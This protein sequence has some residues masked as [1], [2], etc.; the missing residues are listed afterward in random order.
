MNAITKALNDTNRSYMAAKF[1]VD[2]RTAS[3]F[4]NNPGGPISQRADF[5]KASEQ[6][7]HFSG[8]VYASIR[9]I[10]Q[11]IAGQ[12]IHVGK[13]GSSTKL[14]L[15]SADKPDPID[16]HPLLDLLADPNNLMVAWSLMFSTVASL[17]LTGRCLWWLPDQ[18][19][20]LPIPTSWIVGYEGETAFESFKIKPPGSAEAISLPSDEVCYFSY[21][22]PAD[23]WGSTS[24]L[25]AVGRAVDAD[26]A[27]TSSQ[28][29]M[30][31]HGIHP[32]H[33]VKVGKDA[34]GMRSRLTQSQQNQIISAIR[35][36]YAGTTQ[37]GEPLILDGLIEDVSRLSSTV[38]EMD[39]LASGQQ[40]KQRI[41]EGFGTS[42]YITGG[43]EPGSRAASAVASQHFVDYTINPKIELLS[44]CMTEWLSPMFGGGLTIWIEPAISHDA[45]MQLKWAETLAKNG[46]ITAHELRS[47]APLNLSE[48]KAFDGQ[49]V[50]GKNMQ[51]TN[52][53]EQGIRE[54]VAEIFSDNQA[55]KIFKEIEN[56]SSSRM[57]I[58]IGN[59]RDK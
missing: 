12:P 17:E 6:L 52:L 26:E 37:H 59:G 38:Q 46:V 50:G 44:Q 5:A 19:Q 49:L 22:D 33:V 20:I 9:P 42:P 21:P 32:S 55:E 51:T 36:R 11:R 15:K 39:Y 4:A 2:N 40:T 47:L 13:A 8:W 10:A 23:P 54:M 41:Q 48:E 25:Q 58:P 7:K 27:I 3:V 30:F 57:P 53:I 34:N 18:K 31:R 56:A 14:G 45:E 28:A 1:S 35:K 43:S 29:A 24:P 16:S